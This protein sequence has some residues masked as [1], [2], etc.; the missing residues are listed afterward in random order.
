MRQT[1]VFSE[2]NDLLAVSS[3]AAINEGQLASLY[4]SKY[5]LTELEARI[6]HQL[7]G[8]AGDALSPN[9]SVKAGLH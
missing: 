5:E 9:T 3:R 2:R 4:A 8:Q 6:L 1:C 7:P